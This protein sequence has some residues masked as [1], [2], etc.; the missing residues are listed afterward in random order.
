MCLN[1]GDADETDCKRVMY[2]DASQIRRELLTRMK[3]L[4]Q[5]R[6]RLRYY[7]KSPCPSSQALDLNSEVKEKRVDVGD[8]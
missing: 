6:Q 1:H 2:Q 8:Q 7:P 4:F 5:G 3:L